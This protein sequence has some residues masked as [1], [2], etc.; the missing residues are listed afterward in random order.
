[1]NQ[2]NPT[3]IQKNTAIATQLGIPV[4]HGQTVLQAF[5]GAPQILNC[6]CDV[7][8]RQILSTAN[9][10]DTKLAS[11]LFVL[12]ICDTADQVF[13]ILDAHVT[14]NNQITGYQPANPAAGQVGTR[15]A[16]IAGAYNEYNHRPVSATAAT[17]NNGQGG[18]HLQGD[19]VQTLYRHLINIAIQNDG[20]NSRNFNVGHLPNALKNSY[21][22]PVYVQN[23]NPN[24]Q[25]PNVPDVL[26]IPVRNGEAGITSLTNHQRWHNS[27][28]SSIHGINPQIDI[29]TGT[30]ANITAVFGVLQGAVQVGNVNFRQQ[31]GINFQAPLMQLSPQVVPNNQ[32]RQS[33]DALDRKGN[34]ANGNQRFLVG[35]IINIPRPVPNNNVYHQYIANVNLPDFTWITDIIE[36]VDRLWNRKIIIGC[37][38]GHAEIISIQ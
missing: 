36:I 5:R 20:T 17:F 12:D 19:C 1:L 11:V 14:A 37:S 7:I 25:N 22:G 9:A 28:Y 24:I 2:P 6:A 33:L 29:T 23:Y 13:D 18:N 32:I 16:P 15:N 3:N 4:V 10:I 8:V 35:S 30:I 26:A 38:G 34:D 31:Q 21:Y 27:L